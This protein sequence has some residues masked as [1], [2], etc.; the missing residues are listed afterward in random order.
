MASPTFLFH[1]YALG[2]GAAFRR[3]FYSSIPSQASAVVS[4][5][6][7]YAAERVGPSVFVNGTSFQEAS[8]SVTGGPDE[9]GGWITIAQSTVRGL[10]L[11]NGAFYADELHCQLVSRH[12]GAS[13]AEPNISAAGSYINGLRIGGVEIKTGDFLD[14]PETDEGF[15]TKYLAGGE[16]A[17]NVRQWCNWVRPTTIRTEDIHRELLEFYGKSWEEGCVQPPTFNGR[18]ILSTFKGLSDPGVEHVQVF[19]N[20]VTLRNVGRFHLGELSVERGNRRLSMVRFSLGS[21]TEG[22]GSG[23]HSGTN[24]SPYP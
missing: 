18:M 17:K 9:D 5:G 1:G 22:T 8:S 7:G 23:A 6:G 19:G 12:G 24:G 2:F 3:P 10:N 16:W 15:R 21:D 11:L 14:I 20:T 4:I 13:G